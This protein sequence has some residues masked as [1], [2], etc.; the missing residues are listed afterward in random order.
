V[1]C[2]DGIKVQ[3]KVKSGK[4][5]IGKAANE[6]FLNLSAFLAFSMELWCLMVSVLACGSRRLGLSPSQGHC[7]V[8]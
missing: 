7:V 5:L 2:S 6:A 8:A 1:N 3:I 4:R